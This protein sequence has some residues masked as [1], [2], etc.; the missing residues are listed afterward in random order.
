MSVDHPV[1]LRFPERALLRGPFLP[2]EKV[3]QPLGS[4]LPHI[5]PAHRTEGNP[6]TVRRVVG[7]PVHFH[8]TPQSPDQKK[9]RDQ[10]ENS[11]PDSVIQ[12]LLDLGCLI[13]LLW[14]GRTPTPLIGVLR[15]QGGN[16]LFSLF[17]QGLPVASIVV[18]DSRPPDGGIYSW[19]QYA[20]TIR[21][22][23]HLRLRECLPLLRTTFL[24]LVF[25]KLRL[26][27]LEGLEGVIDLVFFRPT[28]LPVL[29]KQHQEHPEHQDHGPGPEIEPS[30]GTALNGLHFTHCR[31]EGAAPAPL[32]QAFNPL[33][34]AFPCYFPAILSL[35][36]ISGSG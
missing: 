12:L 2:I 17:L 8:R 18:Q 23:Y 22:T 1:H 10:Q 25:G 31:C 24:V 28:D 32:D 34:C 26:G 29:Q 20:F 3:S 27:L 30:G 7:F 13:A 35:L 14:N 9:S 21:K 36:P 19:W 11:T 5:N 4:P 15:P 16:R 6:R 33:P